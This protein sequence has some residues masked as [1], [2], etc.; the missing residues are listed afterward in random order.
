VQ[1]FDQLAES[2]RQIVLEL[3][4]SSVTVTKLVDEGD[5]AYRADA[6]WRMTA[7]IDTTPGSFSW[8]KPPASG[9]GPQSQSTDDDGIATFQWK[10]DNAEATSAVSI[11]ETVNAGFD[12]VDA[13]CVVNTIRRGVRSTRLLA[14]SQP[15]FGVTVG[16]GQYATCTVRNR[17]RVGTIEIEKR[18]TPQSSQAFAFDGSLGQFSLVDDEKATAPSKIFAGLTPGTYTVSELVPANW[19]LTGITCVPSSAGVVSGAQVTITLAPNSS[20]VCTYADLR[21][22]PPTPTPTPSPEPG[23]GPEPT[24]GGPAASTEV[25]PTQLQVVKTMRRIARVGSR[26]RFALTV[27]NV[28]TV[29]ATSVQVADVPPASVRLASLQTSGDVRFVRGNAVWRVGTLAPGA[30]RTV[31]G[32]VRITS[33]APGLKRNLAVAAAVNASVVIDP[34]DVRVLPARRASSPSFTG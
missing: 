31:R 29:A 22:E 16:P 14:F 34:A 24:P 7:S 10:P 6:G 2:L 25:P 8:L 19:Q 21:I 26:I 15:T 11:A 27:R 3:C 12:F 20:V 33:G 4:Q 5:G 13:Q 30:S 32:S 18:A 28:G 23:P 9:T 1:D 17:V